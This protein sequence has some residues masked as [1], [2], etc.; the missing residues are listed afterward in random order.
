MT[1]WSKLKRVRGVK[2]VGRGRDAV[3]YSVWIR[4]G[5]NDSGLDFD[6][7]KDAHGL[8][9]VTAEATEFGCGAA[10]VAPTALG[11][12]GEIVVLFRFGIEPWSEKS[13]DH[14]R[15]V[16][17]FGEFLDEVL[18]AGRKPN[19]VLG[20]ENADGEAH[21]RE[22]GGKPAGLSVKVGGARVK[23]FFSRSI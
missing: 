15:Y 19:G 10:E 13:N 22:R 21:G 16:A 7:V 6:M 5:E 12:T 3:W 18:D 1:D 17:A 8:W 9:S 2:E 20:G 23:S 14:Y 11:R 4:P